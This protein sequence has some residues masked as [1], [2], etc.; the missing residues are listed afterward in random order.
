[1]VLDMTNYPD[2]VQI[3]GIHSSASTQIL[4]VC[5]SVSKFKNSIKAMKEVEKPKIASMRLSLFPKQELFLS[6]LW[7]GGKGTVNNLNRPN[8][9]GTSHGHLK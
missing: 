1:M 4:S 5:M 2:S 8:T 7:F 6:L 3:R 9:T